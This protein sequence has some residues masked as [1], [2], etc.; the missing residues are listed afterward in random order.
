M[1]ILITGASSGIGKDMAKELSDLGYELILVARDE[2]KL[3]SLKQ[4]LE[5][6]NK[7]EVEYYVVDLSKTEECKQLYEKVKEKQVEILINNAGFGLF[8]EFDKTDLEA[9]L[10]MIDTNIKA[11][12]I[13]TKLFLQDMIKQ[14]R[15]IILNVASVAS[16]LPGPLMN[17]YYATKNYV[18]RFSQGI[19][20]E[21]KKK[22][23]K[24]SISVLCPGPV[25]TN[26]NEVAQVKFNLHSLSSKTVA[27]Y[28]IRKMLKHKFY[29]LPG[30]TAKMLK[31]LTK[32]SPDSLNAKFCYIVQKKKEEKNKLF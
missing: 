24:V 14:D 27:H 11:V 25:N 16:F 6:K 28:A 31:I 5:D 21:L 12:H 8:G 1:K 19:K 17:T 18:L 29:I 23:S 13:L 22:K 4:E 26:F 9:E 3:K 2:E 7:K 32:L 30:I 15:G 10:N 20:E